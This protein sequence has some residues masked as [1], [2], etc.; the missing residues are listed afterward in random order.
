MIRITP[1]I[2]LNEDEISFDFVR[3]SGPGGQNVNKVSTAVQL[4]FDAARSPSLPD[5]VRARLIRLA[6][7]RATKEGVI[8]IDARRQ[9]TQERNRQEAVDRL[10]A[11][12]GQAAEVRPQRRPTKPTSAARQ[13]RL[14][15]K[16]RRADIKRNRRSIPP[17]DD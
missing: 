1:H 17:T 3:A 11:L 13:R 14:R 16:K 6:G 7:H 2:Q 15:H 10:V 5:E 9:R 8:V 4:R 12:I